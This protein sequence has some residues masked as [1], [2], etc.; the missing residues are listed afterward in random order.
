[1]SSPSS[2][3]NLETVRKK[4]KKRRRR[5]REAQ[6]TCA[7]AADCLPP[8]D[9][10]PMSFT[11]EAEEVPEEEKEEE[12]ARAGSPDSFPETGKRPLYIQ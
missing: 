10:C 9:D 5:T 11:L 8:A 7:A 2:S 12:E 3:W 1:M 6:E 4:K